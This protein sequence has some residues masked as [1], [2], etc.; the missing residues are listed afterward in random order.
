[1]ANSPEFREMIRAGAGTR[2][3][4]FRHRG[5]GRRLSVNTVSLDRAHPA[6]YCHLGMED[7]RPFAPK[8]NLH[9][10][11]QQ[12]VRPSKLKFFRSLSVTN[13]GP[14]AIPP[15]NDGLSTRVVVQWI[16]NIPSLLP[17]LR[18]LTRN[19]AH[20]AVFLLLHL[21]SQP[22]SN[23][24]PKRLLESSIFIFRFV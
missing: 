6:H 10:Q 19:L 23:S 2:R 12:M 8:A 24:T 16:R 20:V 15:R 13:A 21:R 1:M 18:T 17:A 7:V 11:R 14:L 5:C 9:L 3:Q 22:L 4:R